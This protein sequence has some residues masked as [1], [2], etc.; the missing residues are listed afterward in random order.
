MKILFLLPHISCLTGNMPYGI[1]LLTAVLR[2][3]GHKV[4]LFDTSFYFDEY[5]YPS[6]GQ[7][8]IKEMVPEK[9]YSHESEEEREKAIISNY[10]KCRDKSI[11]AFNKKVEDFRPDIIALSALTPDFERGMR[12]YRGLPEP[13]PVLIIGGVHAIVKSEKVL[14]NPEVKAVCIGDGVTSI[15][16]LVEAVAQKEDWDNIPNIIYRKNNELVKTHRICMDM[17]KE[18]LPDFS[19]FDDS[20]YKFIYRAENYRRLRIEASRGCPYSCHFCSSEVIRK[21]FA[22]N[23]WSKV[24]RRSPGKAIEHIRKLVGLHNV[25]FVSLTDENFFGAPKEWV[26]K[27]A[28]LY[29][30]EIN[31]P[32]MIMTNAR[33]VTESNAKLLKQMNCVSISI[34]LES[35]NEEY[36]K[37]I[38]NKRETD[39]DLIRASKLAEKYNIRCQMLLMIGLPEQTRAIIDDTIKLLRKMPNVAVGV[40][41]YDPVPGSK[42][43]N[44]CESKNLVESLSEIEH[45][46]ALG[47]PIV[48]IGCLNRKEL[49]GIMRTIFLYSKVPEEMFPLVQKCEVASPEADQLLVKLNNEFA[50]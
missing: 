14:E 13:R 46:L 10:L 1:G 18:P 27:F 33:M 22:G 24:L 40:N 44:D 8:K 28:N 17:E 49:L 38:L 12:H 48:E 39:A 7:G 47:R 19:D 31:L 36:R 30:K 2:S 50:F 9:T 3:A 23:D 42:I 16:P 45:F 6:L 29:E 32:F 26:E 43:F 5:P 15:L 11:S 21:S 35:G 41:Y 20:H 37:N 4:G 34:G 25:N